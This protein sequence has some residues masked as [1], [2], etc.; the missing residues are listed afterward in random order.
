MITITVSAWNGERQVTL[1]DYVQQWTAQVSD[2]WHLASTPQD[3]DALK[4][5]KKTVQDMAVKRFFDL[6]NMQKDER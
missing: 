5:M 1:D 6:Y 3:N 2:L 4:Q